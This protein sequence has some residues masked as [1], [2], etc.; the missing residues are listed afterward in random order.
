M[1]SESVICII[2]IV[3]DPLTLYASLEH[4]CTKFKID[5]QKLGGIQYSGIISYL[6]ILRC[7]LFSSRLNGTTNEVSPVQQKKIIDIRS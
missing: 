1:P 5:Q 7:T 2:G 6:D 4:L 3:L